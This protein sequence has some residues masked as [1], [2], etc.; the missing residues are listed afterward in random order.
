MS[1][2]NNFCPIEYD[3]SRENIF[4]KTDTCNSEIVEKRK[5]VL[6]NIVITFTDERMV[7]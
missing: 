1:W 6:Y 3:G 7:I 2:R 4:L 5:K